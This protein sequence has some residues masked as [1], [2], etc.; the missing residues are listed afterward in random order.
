MKMTVY[1]MNSLKKNL[2]LTSKHTS[3]YR[4]LINL[5]PFL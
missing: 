3:Y 4:I 2:K 1:S 5:K